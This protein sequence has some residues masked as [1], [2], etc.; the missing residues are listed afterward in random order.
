[1]EGLR[2]RFM[3]DKY[4]RVLDRYYANGLDQREAVRHVMGVRSPGA[5]S[6]YV[7]NIF[8]HE[9][10]IHEMDVRAAKLEKKFD[11]SQ[12]KIVQELAKIGF[13]NIGDVI[14][15]SEDGEPVYD[16]SK[17]TPEFFAA[18]QGLDIEEY[19]DGKDAT[20][21]QVKRFKLKLADKR[22]SLVDIARI[23]GY[24]KLNVNINIDEQII[25]RLRRG[26][27]RARLVEGPVIDAVAER[28]A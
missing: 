25:D 12:E 2:R 7:R 20:A 23:L 11:L 10:I 24:D 19:M 4:L 21:R 27:E 28:V 26:R 17:A 6:S 5:I 8:E 3:L 9:R 1:M 14:T 13:A 18:L 15:I 22:Q 16:F